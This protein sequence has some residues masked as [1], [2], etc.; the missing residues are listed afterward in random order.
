[1][2]WSIPKTWTTGAVLTKTD[3]DKEVRDNLNYLK[4][5]IALEGA[6]ELTIAGNAL[7][8]GFTQSHHTID[9][10]GDEA[11]DDLEQIFGGTEGQVVLIRPADGARVIVV[12]HN[13]GNIWLPG[14]ADISLDQADAYL[15][16]V[17]S[18]VNWVAIAGSGA[19]PA[20]RIR[21]ANAAPASPSEGDIYIDSVENA[22][23]IATD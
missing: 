17:Y 9:T 14:A 23:Y 3:L 22:L 11:S 4:L 7:Y 1:V 10:E 12:K 19:D 13:V 15:M 2:S 16:L 21:V 20:H 6:E 8:P 5:N 18:G